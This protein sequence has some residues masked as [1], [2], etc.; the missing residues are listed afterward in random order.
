MLPY[1]EIAQKEANGAT[2][3]YAYS[4][5]DSNNVSTSLLELADKYADKKDIFL[6]GVDKFSNA[7][8]FASNN[9]N[10]YIGREFSTQDCVFESEYNIFIETNNADW[11][12]IYFDTVGNGYPPEIYMSDK[13]VVV[14]SPVVIVPRGVDTITIDRWN[15]PN[16]PLIIRGIRTFF[17]VRENIKE[18]DFSG[19]DRQDISL[20]SWGICANSGNISLIDRLGFFSQAYTAQTPMSAKVFLGNQQIATF[21]VTIENVDEKKVV[22]MKLSDKVLAWQ[23]QDFPRFLNQV[24]PSNGTGA[25]TMSEML[26]IINIYASPTVKKE[27]S[28][29]YEG[30]DN[31]STQNMLENIRVSVP[32]IIEEGS[33]WSAFVKLCESTGCYIYTDEYGQPKIYYDGGR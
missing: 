23:Q 27:E 16:S 1:I 3:D 7:K 5:I 33:V 20:P 9:E 18:V 10:Y 6:L 15:K 2:I 22:K 17:S 25:K 28:H 19:Q 21:N 13:K 14:Q 11:V 30:V 29:Y 12:V 31:E 32:Q 8:G 4:N 24:I 26:D